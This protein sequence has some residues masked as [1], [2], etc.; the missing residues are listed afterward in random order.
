[1][2]SGDRK[3]GVSVSRVREAGEVV[4]PPIFT[5][6]PRSAVLPLVNGRGR[7]CNRVGPGE[8]S[9]IVKT[10]LLLL[11]VL[12]CVALAGCSQAVTSAPGSSPT[13]TLVQP[14]TGSSLAQV[15]LTHDPASRIWLPSGTTLTYTADQPNLLIAVGTLAQADQVQSYLRQTL[16]GLGWQIDQ[17]AP[18]GLLFHDG[19]WHGAYALGTTSWALTV[20]ND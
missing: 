4:R 16:P 17:D 5:T 14:T 10:V 1:M 8:S 18:G 3:A 9:A 20:R 12:C 15:G 7:P 6:C 11:L 13:P 19:Q 2:V